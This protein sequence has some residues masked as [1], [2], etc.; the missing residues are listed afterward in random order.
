MEG[1]CKLFM[2]NNQLESFPDSISQLRSLR[3]IGLQNNRLR[4]FP[5]CIQH[6]NLTYANL[7]GNPIKKYPN[8]LE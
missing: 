4:E 2:Q 8:K 7:S 1:L 5:E 3:A 6:L